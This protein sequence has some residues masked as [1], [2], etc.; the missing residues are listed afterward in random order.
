MHE[1]GLCE[2]ILDAVEKRAGDRPVAR[3]RVRVGRLHHVHPDAFEQSFA[4]VA[5][6]SVADSAASELVLVSVTGRCLSCS[7]VFEASEPILA[8]PACG[9]LGVEQ[10]GGDELML[11]LIEY[12]A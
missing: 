7:E 9:A 1:L 6:G 2:A 10:T 4:L 3:V 8:C 12:R 11:E 5:S